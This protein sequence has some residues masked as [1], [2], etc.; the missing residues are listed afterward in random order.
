MILVVT[1]AVLYTLIMKAFHDGFD[2]HIIMEYFYD[3]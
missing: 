3:D 2:N 1:E